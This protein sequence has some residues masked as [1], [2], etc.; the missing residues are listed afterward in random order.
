GLPLA[1]LHSLRAVARRLGLIPEGLARVDCDNC[2]GHRLVRPCSTLELGPYLDDE[3][4]DPELD[5]PAADAPPD[6]VELRPLTVGDARAL[7]RALARPGPLRITRAVARALGVVE[8]DGTRDP[9]LIA[10]RLERLPDTDFDEVVA[11]FEALAYPRRLETPHPCAGCDAT[12]WALAPA[13]REFSPV[14]GAM[15]E[16]APPGSPDGAATPTS[17]AAPGPARIETA[18]ARLPF[19][20][21]EALARRLLDPLLTDAERRDVVLTVWEGP[22]HCDAGGN[23]LLG[24]YVPG[25]AEGPG[26]GAPTITIYHRTFVTEVAV[27]PAFDVEAELAETLEHELLHH[28]LGLTGNDAMDDDER[29][30]LRDGELR[31]VGQQETLRRAVAEESATLRGFV[32]ATW[33]VWLLLALGMAYPYLRG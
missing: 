27:D 3:L 18:A 24:S 16:R 25:A 2:G 33:W 26:T 15:A 20:P 17:E 32:R 13:E 23:P 4:D 5:V 1:A 31:R 28:R 10:R 29:A 12:L 9:G 21:F 19:E 8:L 22:A 11:A 14:E 7:H 6:R 30:L